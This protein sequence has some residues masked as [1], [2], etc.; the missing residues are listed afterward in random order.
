[1]RAVAVAHFGAAS[2]LRRRPLAV[3]VAVL[4]SLTGALA[5]VFA[6]GLHANAVYDEGVYLASVDALAHGQTLGSEVFASQPP[7]FYALLQG[8][9]IL[10]GASLEA[11]R[12]AMLVLALLGCLAAY[13][14]ARSIGGR[15]AGVVA[16]AL[17]ATPLAVED[18]AVRVRADFPSVSLSLLSIG[19]A[20]LAVI[21]REGQ[22][23]TAGVLAGGAL[24]AAVS[25]KLLAAT[26]VVPVLAIV[27]V[28]ARRLVLAVAAGA[29]AVAVVF[30]GAYAGVLGALWDDVVRFHLQAQSRPIQG[31]P[32]D[33]RGNIA[34]L[35]DVVTGS[36]G[37]R[38]PFAWLV[39]AGAMGTAAAWRRKT[40]AE[41]VPLW[42]WAAVS[43]AF[44]AWHRPLWAHDVVMLTVA[45]A[46][47]A[48]VG[49]A[50]LLAERRPIPRVVAG[51]CAVVIAASLAHHVERT[52]PGEDAGVA[53]A[54]GILRANTP[55]GSEVASDLPIVPFLADR[56]QPGALIDTSRTRLESGSLTTSMIVDQ[57]NRDPLSAV[58][59]G[60]N[61]AS[62][63]AIIRAAQARFP[64]TVQRAGLTLAGERPSRVRLYLRRSTR[65]EVASWGHRR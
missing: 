62:S 63:H 16:M 5:A 33:I 15:V 53:W 49:I 11:M 45:L 26:A 22:R 47:S 57:I 52:P 4:L 44:L 55:P 61:F 64:F 28:R 59:I 65:R 29:A 9:R 39:V 41:A 7:G 14:V 58:I 38:S 1:M 54:A 20:R 25:V 35:L 8:D 24:A 23:L 13:Y 50:A 18:E 36:V 30:V 32:G 17:V 31:A 19:L 46:V 60:H 6:R 3:E 27:L 43:A 10:F 37:I 56:R 2:A 42:L 40:A 34:K 12:L 48:G 21:G 51:F